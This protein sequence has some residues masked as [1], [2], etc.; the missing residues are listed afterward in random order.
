MVGA[1]DRRILAKHILPNAIFPTLVYASMDIGNVVLTFAALS[2]LGVGTEVGYADWGQILSFA[3]DWITNLS[4]YWYIVAFPGL[5]LL[6]FVLS[7]N[8]VGDALRDVLD[9]RMRGSR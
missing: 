1:T 9:P 6:L 2:F 4:T 3:R 5:F 8:L 7:F